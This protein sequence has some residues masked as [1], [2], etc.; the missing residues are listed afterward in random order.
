M[1][2]APWKAYEAEVVGPDGEVIARCN[3][4]GMACCVAAVPDF[5]EAAELADTD[6]ENAIRLLRIA[7]AK[8]R[9]IGA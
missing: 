4:E 5:L 2:P 9:G 3:S 1:D 8:A 7:A 6:P